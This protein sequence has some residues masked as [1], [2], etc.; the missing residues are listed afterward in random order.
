MPR[1]AR[2]RSTIAI[3]ATYI[4]VSLGFEIRKFLPEPT[5]WPWLIWLIAFILSIFI[6]RSG[7][8]LM[9]SLAVRIRKI[10][11]FILGRTWIE[12]TWFFYTTEYVNEQ[13]MSAAQ[14][15]NQQPK[16]TQ[17]GLAQFFYE[18]PDS[19][20]RAR[21][22]DRISLRSNEP[23]QLKSS[24]SHSM[25]KGIICIV[26]CDIT[27]MFQAVGAAYG[28]FVCEDGQAPERYEG[29]VIFL[30]V[31]ETHKRRQTGVKLP[32]KDVKALR[33]TV[34][35]DWARIMLNNEEWVA[36]FCKLPERAKVKAV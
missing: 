18:L 17:I 25:R 3:S 15:A 36:K 32:F 6:A 23:I 14:Y 21:C 34:G 22:S 8:S 28:T 35:S 13:P 2:L 5:R 4:L 9:W 30:D 24:V 19:S 7:T 27:R 11:Q 20:C 16:I 33:H 29:G 31:E 26:L 10:R 1:A 12:G